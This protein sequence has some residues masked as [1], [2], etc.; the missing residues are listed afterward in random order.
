V[1]A[2]KGGP[3]LRSSAG[4]TKP[5]RSL[6]ILLVLVIAGFAAMFGTDATSPRLAIDL[7]G[8]T[9]VTLTAKPLPASDGG[10]GGKL[11]PENMRQAVEIIRKR[12]NSF[13]VSEA[14]VTTL[15]ADNIVVAIPGNSSS[16][17]AQQV[18]QTALLRFR[19]VIQEG[20]PTSQIA[21]SPSVPSTG[22]LPD[23]PGMPGMPGQ[24]R[25]VSGAL[26]ASPPPSVP[27]VP[28]PPPSA[29]PGSSTSTTPASTTPAPSASA[30]PTAG[31]TP[32]PNAKPSKSAQEIASAGIP[33]E[34]KREFVRRDCTR[35]DAKFIGDQAPASAYVVAC[36]RD[37]AFK[38]VLGPSEVQGTDVSNALASLPQGANV[39]AWQI[40]LTFNGHGTSTFAEVTKR[41]AGHLGPST[42]SRSPWTAWCSRRRR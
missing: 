29:A 18:G 41:L 3:R 13:G 38:Y 24:P 39:G 36:D 42:S 31:A 2:S 15:G 14:Q 10:N 34:V 6:V 12:V 17:V 4:G 8:G 5:G 23:M 9:S 1:A 7:A 20:P 16:N 26:L 32:A 19:E 30:A 28:V 21:S 33:D 40:D 27:T 22:G 25:V 11:T 35:P 37:G